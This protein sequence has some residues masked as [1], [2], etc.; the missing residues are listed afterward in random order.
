MNE[1]EMFKIFKRLLDKEEISK[2][3]NDIIV[4]YPTGEYELYGKYSIIS[5][6]GYY[7]AS[8]HYTHTSKKFNSLKNAVI[9]TT[10]D[11]CNQITESIRLLELDLL[12]ASTLEHIKL[13]EKNYKNAKNFEVLTLADTKLQEER[14]RKARIMVE[15]DHYANMTSRWQ[16]KQFNNLSAK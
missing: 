13:H 15:L 7:I 2:I 12:L 1:K 5:S 16:H 6:D 4:Q 8:K 9:W 14:V 10:L 3:F 11:R